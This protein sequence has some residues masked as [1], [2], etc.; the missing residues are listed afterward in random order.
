MPADDSMVLGWH[1]SGPFKC[2]RKLERVLSCRAT[3]IQYFFNLRSIIYFC[4]IFQYPF[5]LSRLSKT[6]ATNGHS[7][8]LPPEAIAFATRMYDAARSGQLDIFEQALPRGL[9][10]NMTN[11]KGDT[12]VRQ[13]F[14][15]FHVPRTTNSDK[16]SDNASSIPRSCI[17]CKTIARTWSRSK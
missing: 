16:S 14:I 3:L 17:T 15:I 10:P 12:L 9:P 13:S 6:M 11:E 4:R 5:K 1:G 8:G 2:K 7:Q